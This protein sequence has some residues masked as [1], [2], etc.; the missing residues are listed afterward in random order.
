MRIRHAILPGMVGL[1]VVAAV[2]I[3]ARTSEPSSR[4]MPGEVPRLAAASQFDRLLAD[5]W[6]AAG[7]EPSEPAD[8]LTVLRRLSLALHGTIPSLEEL[9]QFEADDEPQR[10]ARWT[11]RMLHDPRF[12]NYFAERLVR[13]M[14]GTQQG[15]FAIHRRDR[16]NAWLAERLLSDRPWDQTVSHLISDEGVWTETP[17]ANFV[18]MNITDDDLDENAMTARTV[19]AFLGQRIDCA[20][21]HDHPFDHWKQDQFEGLAA[22]YGQ[23]GLSIGGLVDDPTQTYTVQDRQTLEDRTIA[24]AFPFGDDWLSDADR[25][26]RP[27]LQLARWVTH[28]N[29]RRLDRAIVNRVWTLMMGRPLDPSRPVDD[30]PDPPSAGEDDILGLAVLVDEFR[31]GGR[32]IQPLIETIA[33]TRAFRMSS[34]S[35]LSASDRQAATELWAVR[36]LV[37]LRPEQAIGAMLQAGSIGTIDRDSHLIVR[38]VRSVR[39]KGFVDDYGDAGDAE[40]EPRAATTAQALLRMNGKLVREITEANPFTASGRLHIVYDGR[41]EQ[42]VR[43]AYL[44]CLTREPT[45]AER[46]YLAA[47]LVELED[48]NSEQAVQD[49]FWV[50]FNSPEFSWVR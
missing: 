34:V 26:Q 28:E 43:A 27:R 5:E 30:L 11:R 13:P 38:I 49:L 35:A 48:R 33:A 10:L 20:Q 37:Q 42:L 31:R 39:E 19:R 40:L 44:T 9:R 36:P 25:Q 29:N 16:L 21:C 2:A 32:R 18:T 45:E 1:S 7:V 14:V 47:D 6:E 46:E 24:P 22:C 41:P 3:A 15:P 12:G 8:D 4:A 50:L 17:A 23:A